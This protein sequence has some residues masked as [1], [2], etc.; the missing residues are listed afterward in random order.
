MTTIA[1]N[2]ITA[3][4]I[5]A[6]SGVPEARREAASL[7]AMA[8]ERDRA[9]LRAHPEYSLGQIELDRFL[10]YVRRRSDR[11]PLQYIRGNQ[12][13]YGLDFEI[14]P[15]VLIPR[16]ETEIIVEIALKFLASSDRPTF[17][18]VGIGSGCITVSI[19]HNLP[20]AAS[21][22]LDISKEALEISRKNAITH[23]VDGRLDLR[24]SDIYSAVRDERFDLI[25]SNPPY[26]PARDLDSLQ[27]EVRE[28]EPHLA[29]FGGSDGLSI[30]RS[31]AIDAPR[32]LRPDGKLLMEIGFDQA[33]AVSELFSVDHWAAVEIVPDLQGVPRTVVAN[34]KT[35]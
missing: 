7:L 17:C 24:H 13:F 1:E 4:D 9:F 18:E 16:P 28:F 26:V 33:N 27:V 15:D 35:R 21:V 12:E 23:G 19:L 32:F 20:V 34:V 14:S 29:L 8:L 22:G 10:S 31:I 11:E 2:L 3:A 6:E 30:I 5:L 25:V